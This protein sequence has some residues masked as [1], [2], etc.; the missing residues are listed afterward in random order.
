[1]LGML[2]WQWKNA[3]KKYI[4]WGHLA[5]G[6]FIIHLFF[7]FLL[8][9][10]CRYGTTHIILTMKRN[11]SFIPVTFSGSPMRP[12]RAVETIKVPVPVQKKKKSKKITPRKTSVVKA[13]PVEKKVTKKATPPKKVV[14]K[15]EI[16]KI[17]S[18]K[19]KEIQEVAKPV[20]E[21][22]PEVVQQVA[23]PLPALAVQDLLPQEVDAGMQ[24]VNYEQAELYALVAKQWT[25]PVG[26]AKDKVCEVSADIGWNQEITKVWISEKSGILMYD[27]AARKAV[28][29]TQFPLWT[30]GKTI[31]IRFVQ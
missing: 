8:F 24:S 27:I 5:A 4:I 11:V 28:M 15:K 6:A 31:T 20:I 9:F 19:K 12:R 3:H 30:R 1:M 22:V 16:K 17:V 25:P 14:E 26:I 21:K 13:K 10:Y 23:M 7:G 2:L 18:E 29:Q